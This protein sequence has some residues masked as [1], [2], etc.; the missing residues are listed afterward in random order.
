MSDQTLLK[1]PVETDPMALEGSLR[2][3]EVLQQ[4]GE[5]G[6]HAVV[7][8]KDWIELRQA[9]EEGVHVVAQGLLTGQ[10]GSHPSLRQGMG[11]TVKRPESR[12]ESEMKRERN[13]APSVAPK[14]KRAFRK[15]PRT[16]APYWRCGRQKAGRSETLRPRRGHK[17]R[18][19]LIRT[20]LEKPGSKTKRL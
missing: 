13:A 9:R 15:R 2:A 18:S 19:T 17:S 8:G 14:S 7:R 20:G 4:G 11:G 10:E 1:L 6:R 16:A 3:V 5:Q 12:P